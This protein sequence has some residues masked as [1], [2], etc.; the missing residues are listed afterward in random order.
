[1]RTR[2]H[3]V[4]PD[5]HGTCVAMLVRDTRGQDLSD[6]QRLTHFPASPLMSLTWSDGQQG[7]LVSRTAQGPRW[8]PF[9]T[10]RLI[11]GSQSQPTVTWAPTDGRVGM[12]CFTADVARSL[13]GLDPAAVQDRF[14]AADAVLDAG[15]R[16]LLDALCATT[17]DAAMLRAL[18]THIAPRWLALRREQPTHAS[19]RRSGRHWVESL[20]RCAREWTNLRSTRQ[21]ERRIKDFSGRSLREWQSLVRT[22]GLFFA[23]RERRDAGLGY[24]W[25]ALAQEEG[26]ADQAHLSRQTRRITGFAPGEFARRYE[27]DESFWAYR[28]WI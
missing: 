7:G 15:W 19:L 18:Q 2:L 21:V 12:L 13:F 9:G 17:D 26:F 20:A 1:M 3:A 14:V 6:A 22:E 5:L 27:E 28:L 11:G 4:P 8:T 24:D 25:A 16:P 10:S 23:A